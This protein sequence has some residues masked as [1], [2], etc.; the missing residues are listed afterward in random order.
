[1]D[2]SDVNVDEI[3]EYESTRASTHHG[4]SDA[5]VLE[6]PDEAVGD[7]IRRVD[8]N[9]MIRDYAATEPFQVERRGSMFQPSISQ[10][11]VG[12][13]VVRASTT[14]ARTFCVRYGL[15]VSMSFSYRALG[16]ADAEILARS[17]VYKLTYLMS[18][19]YPPYQ[20]SYPIN[21]IYEWRSPVDLEVLL[22]RPDGMVKQRAMSIV[23]MR[24]MHIDPR[25]WIRRP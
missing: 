11:I 16:A 7:A 2:L 12:S 13:V 23:H 3:Y 8:S 19:V 20:D 4:G 25:I 24:P 10:N 5:D 1:M 9:M 6:E 17:A 22:T 18:Q 14:N 21:R 15:P